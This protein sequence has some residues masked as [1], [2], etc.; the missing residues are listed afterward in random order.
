MSRSNPLLEGEDFEIIG[1]L[2]G[3][4]TFAVRRIRDLQ[5]LR[6]K[7]GGRRWRKVKGYALIRYLHSGNVRDAELHWYECHGIGIKERKVK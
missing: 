1:S 5:R 6:E 3:R 4:Q 2:R 7:Y